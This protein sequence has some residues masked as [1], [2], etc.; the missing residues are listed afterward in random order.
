MKPGSLTEKR[1]ELVWNSTAENGQQLGSLPM[2][3]SVIH[4]MLFSLSLTGK[5]PSAQMI[6]F[7]FNW[8]L[9]PMS[10]RPKSPVID[11]IL[12]S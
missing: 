6:L 4:T 11:H 12:A 1:F 3:Q 8:S 7:F 2:E 9:F 10:L 5:L